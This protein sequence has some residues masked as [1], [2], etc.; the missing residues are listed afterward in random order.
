M[1]PPPTGTQVALPPE[2]DSLYP[3]LQLAAPQVGKELYEA[4]FDTA[5][6]KFVHCVVAEGDTVY[7][8]DVVGRVAAD[9]P[10]VVFSAHT[11]VVPLWLT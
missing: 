10:G 8:P 1:P 3:A 9:V 2:P 7:V 5:L 4:A 6:H 11:R